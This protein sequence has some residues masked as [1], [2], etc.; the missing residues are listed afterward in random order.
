MRAPRRAAAAAIGS[1]K[2]TGGP[3]GPPVTRRRLPGYQFPLLGQAP[4]PVAVQVRCTEAPV[5]VLVIVNSLPEAEWPTS[6]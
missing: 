5:P 1:K 6:T 2:L 4:L 3:E